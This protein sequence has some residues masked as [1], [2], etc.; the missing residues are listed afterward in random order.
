MKKNDEY[1]NEDTYQTLKDLKVS[2]E[3][4]PKTEYEKRINPIWT[5]DTGQTKGKILCLLLLLYMINALYTML[6]VYLS[7]RKCASIKK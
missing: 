5:T 7:F 2:S 3:P 4:I 1:I 6:R